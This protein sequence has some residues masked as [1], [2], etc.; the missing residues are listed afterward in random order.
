MLEVIQK[1]AAVLHGA[2]VCARVPAELLVP[3][4]STHA[5]ASHAS[6]RTVFRSPRPFVLR[7]SLA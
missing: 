1:I 2:L 7:F 6:A 3:E 4:A 5:D